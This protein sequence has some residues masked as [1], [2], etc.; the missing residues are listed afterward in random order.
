RA[1]DWDRGGDAHYRIVVGG[2][3]ERAHAVGR[4]DECGLRVRRLERVRGK[5]QITWQRPVALQERPGTTGQDGLLPSRRGS[6]RQR[7]REC[8]RSWNHHTSGVHRPPPCGRSLAMAL[9]VVPSARG[10]G[11][12]RVVAVTRFHGTRYFSDRRRMSATVTAS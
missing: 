4:L 12:R 10:C 2:N 7:R 3:D 11:L 6:P 9:V 8:D 5:P 1:S